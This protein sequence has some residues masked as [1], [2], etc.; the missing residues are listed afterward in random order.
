MTKGKKKIGYQKTA[1]AKYYLIFAFE[2]KYDQDAFFRRFTVTPH[3]CNAVQTTECYSDTVRYH[4]AQL[5]D[6]K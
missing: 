6:S 1:Y 3:L 5:H 4:S 2:V